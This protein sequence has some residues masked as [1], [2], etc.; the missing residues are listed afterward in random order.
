MADSSPHPS[1]SPSTSTSTPT[2]SPGW[3][4][5]GP[6]SKYHLRAR[7]KHPRAS[8]SAYTPCAPQ[9]STESRAAVRRAQSQQAVVQV[10]HVLGLMTPP[11]P[12]PLGRMSRSSWSVHS[13]S[14]SSRG[15]G[16]DGEVA[17]RS[18]GGARCFATPA[19]QRARTLTLEGSVGLPSPYSDY[20]TDEARSLGDSRRRRPNTADM[21]GARSR[22]GVGVDVTAGGACYAAP[23][24]ETQQL[25]VRLNKLQAQLMRGDAGAEKGQALKIVGRKM[26]EIDLELFALCSQ[27]MDDSGSFL[28][29]EEDNP[30]E[31][32]EAR[33]DPAVSAPAADD[34]YAPTAAHKRAER[35]FQLLEAQ[36]VLANVTKAQEELRKRHAELALLNERHVLQIE[37]RDQAIEQLRSE[38]EGLQADLG[39]DHSEL[40]F[41]KLQ[42]EALEVDGGG[43]REGRA[44]VVQAMELWRGDWWDVQARVKRRQRKCGVAVS[45][46]RSRG[47]GAGG[48]AEEEGGA[49]EWKVEVVRE[50]VGRRVSRI[51]VRRLGGSDVRTP[52]AF[53]GTSDDDGGGVL[54]R[55]SSS[56]SSFSAHERP[57]TGAREAVTTPAGLLSS[58][59]PTAR[60]PTTDGAALAA[61]CSD[62]GILPSAVDVSPRHSA[63]YVHQ[64]TQTDG[65]ADV[66][67]AV[68][69]V[70]YC[71]GEEEGDGDGD[72]GES[73]RDGEEE[74]EEEEEEEQEQE[75]QEEEEQ[76]EQ[77]QEERDGDSKAPEAE[78]YE[79]YEEE[80]ASAS[81]SDCAITT[82]PPTPQ[83][84]PVIHAMRKQQ[85]AQDP[86]RTTPLSAEPPPPSSS[87]KSAW[88]ELWEGLGQLAGGGEP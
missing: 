86:Q 24:S 18:A 49:G 79:D 6:S 1:P 12:S 25:L 5:P 42:M 33:V 72:G 17:V 85:P 66:G 15:D 20:F 80:E 7:P 70:E 10:V 23:S 84:S 22:M 39:F 9:L 52:A 54:R 45:P 43:V 55:F 2:S 47:A 28:E 75:E 41:L 60:M 61:L 51:V 46:E 57:G 50:R 3:H 88:Q 13:S 83:S 67:H 34:E 63:E 40:L 62:R 26:G 19:K 76:E 87:R 59:T 68:P 56:S 81:D 14:T 4:F 38:N 29:D 82:S 8:T 30:T 64:G 78:E 44:G 35:D 27:S 32:C 73:E 65:F 74:E 31:A 71:A 53:A 69:P 36:R 16:K 48:L 37:A 21:T 58:P 11:P 77:E